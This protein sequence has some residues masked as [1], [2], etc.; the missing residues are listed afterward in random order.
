M[1]AKSTVNVGVKSSFRR[2][3]DRVVDYSHFSKGALDSLVFEIVSFLGGRVF[4]LLGICCALDIYA[5]IAVLIS[6]A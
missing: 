1:K 5:N 4:H 6:V 2:L 3:E